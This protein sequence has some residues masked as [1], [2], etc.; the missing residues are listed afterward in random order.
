MC[1][2]VCKSRIIGDNKQKHIYIDVCI[3]EGIVGLTNLKSIE[4]ASR[5]E[6]SERVGVL[7]LESASWNLRQNFYV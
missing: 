5:L 1:M 4:Q 7:G 6:I 2:H 3:Y